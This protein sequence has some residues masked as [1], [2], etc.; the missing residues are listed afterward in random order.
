MKKTPSRKLRASR[1]PLERERRF[2]YETAKPNRFANRVK[3]DAVVV[4]LDSDVAKVFRSSGQVNALLRAT[5]RAVK[6]PR[7]QRAS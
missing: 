2:N 7:P 6:S 3:A 1:D 4:V 5:I